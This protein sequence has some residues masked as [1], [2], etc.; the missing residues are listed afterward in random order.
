MLHWLLFVGNDGKAAL[1]AFGHAVDKN[2]SWTFTDESTRNLIEEY[3][4]DGV[5]RFIPRQDVLPNL[6]EEV[7]Q[8]DHGL[9]P[10]AERF[11]AADRD[12]ERKPGE[13]LRLLST[14]RE[15]VKRALMW[16]QRDYIAK[17][18]T[19]YDPTSD[20]DEDLPIDLDH[21]V[22]NDIFGFDWR[23]CESRIQTDAI[24]EDFRKQR[25]I[26]GNSLGNFRWFDASENR[27]R[28]KG[29]YVPIEDDADLVP[30]PHDW[31]KIIPQGP[32]E[33]PWSKDDI[34]TFQRL[35]DL[36]TLELYEKLLTES[37]IETIL[38]PML[39]PSSRPGA[40]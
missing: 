7:E 5:A 34:A 6:R 4:K 8:G 10:W 28:G 12:G 23:S 3:E 19:N 9:R 36:R 11:T 14:N 27:R 13:A 22:P 29:A 21:I 30:N 35:I 2:K 26:I 25:S 32:K 33:Q 17:E 40:A 20:R 39:A 31:N 15:L 18:F 16:L 24:T 1:R 38:P 37:G